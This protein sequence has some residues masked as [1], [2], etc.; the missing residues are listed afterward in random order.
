MASAAS[1]ILAG[2]ELTANK[3]SVG[4]TV[5]TENVSPLTSAVANKVGEATCVKKVSVK[6]APTVYAWLQKYV[7]VSMAMRVTSVRTQSAIRL[8][9]T[10]MLSALIN[11]LAILVGKGGSVID[12]CVV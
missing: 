11:A 9:S 3:L 10:V 5:Y 8:A 2:L 6:S 4:L 7:L 1:V 12:R